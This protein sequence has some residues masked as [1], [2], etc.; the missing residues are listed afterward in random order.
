LLGSR[1]A[2]SCFPEQIPSKGSRAPMLIV[3]TPEG[4]ER[5]EFEFDPDN[6]WSFEAELIESVGRP[7]WVSF[8]A[9]YLD[10]LRAGN[11]KAR[12]ALLWV[13][14]KREKPE[15]RFVD[16]VVKVNEVRLGM[17]KAER[18]ELRKQL[19]SEDL[20]A[21]DR[22]AIQEALADFADEDLEPEPVG[23]D[24]PEDSATDGPSPT[25]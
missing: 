23:K 15:L 21:A 25:S 17:D 11:F 1:P 10:L 14:L 18:A 7:T 12:R 8:E 13:L 5:R 4:E 2:F 19:E 16:L 24:E 3:Y 9:D 6:A 22:E 20:S